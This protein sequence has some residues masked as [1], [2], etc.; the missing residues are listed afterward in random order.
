M[1]VNAPHDLMPENTSSQLTLKSILPWALLFL[2]LMSLPYLVAWLGPPPGK[3]FVGTFV[4]PDDLSTYLAA[5]RQG[6]D[7]RWLYHFSF[8]PEPWQPKLMLLPYLLLGKVAGLLGGGGLF[9]FHLLRVTAVLLTLLIFLVWVRTLFPGRARLQFTAWLLIVYGS[10]IGWLVAILRLAERVPGGLP[11]LGGP[12][13]SIFMA[14]FH[15]PHFA[16]GVGLEVLLFICVL[17]MSALAGDGR[18]PHIRWAIAGSIVGMALGLT[19]VYHLPVAGLV[20]GFYLLALAWQQRRIPW[21]VWGY[22]LLILL[23]LA[24]LLVYYALLTNQDPYFAAYTQQEHVIPPPPP[25]AALI[26]L[27][28]LGLMALAGIRAWFR[29][30]LTWLVPLWVA[31]NLLLLYLPIVQFSGRFALGLMVPVATLAAWGLEEV[32]LPGLAKR[33]FYTRFSQWTPT[34]YATLRRFFFFLVIPSTIILSL[35]VTK[36]A[37]DAQDFPTYLPAT[38]ITAAHWLAQQSGPDD[39]VLAYYPMGNYLPRVLPGKVFLGQLDYTTDL[40]GKVAL[41]EQFWQPE[42]SLAWRQ[43]LI[44][45]W[46][47]DYIYAG[48]YEALLG[49]TAVPVPGEI[50]YN[51]DGVMI[52]HVI[53]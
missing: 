22:G 35:L 17:K 5:I 13:W 32:L 33:P 41:V 9:W 14:L 46:H 6:G 49:D 37:V 19:Y 53:R 21:R 44:E 50:V 36:T 39:L 24:L 52:Y 48:Q 8:S 2:A 29:A 42:T 34:P 30:Q 18:W 1:A 10:G 23:P 11:D 26:G 15:T 43:A 20:I 40:E 25:L 38:E 16:L 3:V 7:G 47:I 12:E 31:A 51:R 28:F 45:T 4:N 27:G